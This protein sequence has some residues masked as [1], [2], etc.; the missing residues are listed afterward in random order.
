MQ[1][2]DASAVHADTDFTCGAGRDIIELGL[3]HYASVIPSD[4]PSI[5]VAKGYDYYFCVRLT[6]TSSEARTVTLD[7]MRPGY[8]NRKAEWHPSRVPVFISEDFRNWY[9]LDG[10]D[11]SANHE[12]Y[13]ASVSLLPGQT[14][15][16]S[17]SLPYPYERMAA[18][19]RQLQADHNDWA[20]L[21]SLGSSVE[22]RN[23]LLMSITDPEVDD[24]TKD[25]I[26]VTSGFHPAE[27]D[28]LATTSIIKLLLG[29][30]AWAQMVRKEFIVDLVTQVNAD[31]FDLGTNGCNAR[32][33]NLYWDFRPDDGTSSPE[34]A[35]LWRWIEAHPPSL[36]IDF[37]AYVHY[38]HKDFRPYIRPLS[39]YARRARPVVRAIDRELIALCHG[40]QVRG[41]DT[42][43]PTTLAAQITKTL[44][45]ITYTKFH[46]HLLHGIPAC[47]QLGVEVFK[48]I[49]E[50]ARAYRPLPPKVIPPASERRNLADSWLYWWEQSRTAL[51][52]RYLWKLVKQRLGVSKPPVNDLLSTLPESGLAAHWCRHLWSQRERVAP[53]ITV[54]DKVGTLL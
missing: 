34:A 14:V 47:R 17:N 20:R 13:R 18:W 15:Y 41:R 30:D 52:M 29:G 40:R 23:I 1:N 32:G 27:P 22:G 25:R 44:G 36:H 4:P 2:R 8:A 10:V 21:V 5:P 42:N 48:T 37:H 19:L 28:W 46:L 16:L 33:I 54:G 24:L 51:R 38:L 26:L 50:T 3:D 35:Y 11:A 31:G 12:E 6:N 43:L 39:D 9:V 53:V 7:A 49:V 45:T